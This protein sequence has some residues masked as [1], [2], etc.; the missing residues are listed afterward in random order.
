[1]I[2]TTQNGNAVQPPDEGHGWQSRVVLDP[3]DSGDAG[4]SYTWTA[5]TAGS[6]RN[7]PDSEPFP[8]P[9]ELIREDDLHVT[10]DGTTLECGKPWICTADLWFANAAE[11]RKHAAA[12]LDACDEFDRITGAGAL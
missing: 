9:V 8:V 4:I 12:L 7:C 2:N 11:A 3:E 5:R 1:M 6:A 10:E